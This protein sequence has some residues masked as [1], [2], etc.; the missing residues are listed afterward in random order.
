MRAPN[1]TDF[2]SLIARSAPASCQGINGHKSVAHFVLAHGQAFLPRPLPG[3]YQRGVPK[4]C[5][6]NA[7]HL[8]LAH[9]TLTYCEGYAMGV[10]PVNH[11]W[12]C[13]YLGR[14]IEVTW[15]NPGAE[16]FGIPIRTNYLLTRLR[17]QK[18]YG[19]VDRWDERWPMLHDPPSKWLKKIQHA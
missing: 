2:L 18:T 17:V 10:L 5:F 16:Y 11:A 19:L 8:A 12:V 14:V 6:M 3:R 4:S 1:I 15:K 7:A 13:D 9:P